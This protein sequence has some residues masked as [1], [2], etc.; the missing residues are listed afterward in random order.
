MQFCT[1]VRQVPARAAIASIERS[2]D[3]RSAISDMITA[4]AAACAGVNNAARRGGS[5]PAEAHR[6][7]RAMDAAR[8]GEVGVRRPDQRVGCR[9]ERVARL[10]SSSTSTS[11]K[12]SSTTESEIAPADH[13][14]RISRRL[15]SKL[16]TGLRTG[17]DRRTSA[18][19]ENRRKLGD[20]G[21]NRTC[22]QQL[23]RLSLYP[24]SYG[25]AMAGSA[26]EDLGA[27]RAPTGIAGGDPLVETDAGRPTLS[28]SRCRCGRI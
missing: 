2:H 26:A 4:T 1:T 9:M 11:A 19:P 12:S 18:A 17:P 5:H 23:R 15:D 3:P 28:A 16:R 14:A 13:A 21:R 8:S 20:P 27:S 25:A 6:R 7:R 22:D 10:R 24:L